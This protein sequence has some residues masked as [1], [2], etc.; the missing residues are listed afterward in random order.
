MSWEKR[1]Q[2]A[3]ARVCRVLVV[4]SVLAFV[5]FFVLCLMAKAHEIKPAAVALGRG[6]DRQKAPRRLG[7]RLPRRA[8]GRDEA[9]QAAL[10][11]GSSAVPARVDP[12]Q[13]WPLLETPC[14]SG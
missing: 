12:G 1:A 6:H 14:P 10:P 3:E 7:L 5:V 4:L 9:G 11:R 8:T 13:P 2:E